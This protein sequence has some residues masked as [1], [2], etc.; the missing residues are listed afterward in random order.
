MKTL[1]L[2]QDMGT[3]DNTEE[4][5]CWTGQERCI[6][7]DKKAHIGKDRKDTVGQNNNGQ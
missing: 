3:V 4:G 7:R 5:R 6:S 2:R 1:K